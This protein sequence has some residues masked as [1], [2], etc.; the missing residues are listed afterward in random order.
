LSLS[1]H[2]NNCSIVDIRYIDNFPARA[3]KIVLI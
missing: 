1:L 2:S 3:Y